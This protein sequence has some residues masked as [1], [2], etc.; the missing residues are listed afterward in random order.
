MVTDDETDIV[1]ETPALETELAPVQPRGLPFS[2]AKR[3][4]VLISEIGDDHV[5]LL[6]RRNFNPN[7]LAE[8]GRVKNGVRSP[9]DRIRLRRRLLSSSANR[10]S[11]HSRSSSVFTAPSV[12]AVP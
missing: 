11:V 3:H 9:S 5:K 10:S 4:G 6:H 1:L 2:F 12:T 8:I 7:V